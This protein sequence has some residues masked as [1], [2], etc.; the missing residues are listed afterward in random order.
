M[1]S[2]LLRILLAPALIAAASL[3]GRRW[4]PAI[5]GW[6]IGLP[7]T[8]GPV[9]FLLAI[10]YG[11]TFA[12]VAARGTLA[13]TLSLE[14]FTLTYAWVARRNRWPLSFGVATLVFAAATFA[15]QR[16]TLG[17]A[18]LVGLV[19]LSMAVTI[20]LMP[21]VPRSVA[22]P[23]DAT[24]SRWDLP[25]RMLI[26]GG[27]VGGLTA[28]APLLGPH[29]TGMLSPFPIYGSILAIFAH[30][31]LGSDAA[32]GVLRGML[33]GMFA[34]VSFFVVVTTLLEP[35]GIAAAFILAI[36]VAL[37]AHGSSLWLLRRPRALAPAAQ[38]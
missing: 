3:A 4:G 29:L 22:P 32:V 37:L 30:R 36:V 34:F 21:R 10:T 18:P 14:A 17:V 19:L 11:E 15:L 23:P 8:S 1:A 25:A 33:Y 20:A 2:L 9:C 12:A 5:S 26:A 31:Q 24:P 13:G 35:L 16:L 38:G 7:L 28:G 27:V 6:L